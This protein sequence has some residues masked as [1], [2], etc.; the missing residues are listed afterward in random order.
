MINLNPLKFYDLTLSLFVS[1][2]QYKT[3]EGENRRD[4]EVAE[5]ALRSAANMEVTLAD[6][7]KL[8]KALKT[9]RCVHDM[10]TAFCIRHARMVDDGELTDEDTNEDGLG[11]VAV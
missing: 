7:H 9:H 8:T 2:L 10:D 11:G 1:N 3:V 6:I 5:E 4:D